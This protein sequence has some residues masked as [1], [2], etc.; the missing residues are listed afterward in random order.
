LAGGAAPAG[1]HLLVRRLHGARRW[2]TEEEEND[3]RGW[4][5]APAAGVSGRKRRRTN[6]G[7]TTNEEGWRLER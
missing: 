2:L 3:E 6:A 1:H 7:R 5:D 4:S